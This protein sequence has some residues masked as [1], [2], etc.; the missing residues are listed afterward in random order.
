MASR[1]AEGALPTTAAVRVKS[2][3]NTVFESAAPGCTTPVSETD[4]R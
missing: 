3:V 2:P 1:I 4:R